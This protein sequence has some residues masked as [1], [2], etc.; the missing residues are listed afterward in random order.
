VRLYGRA[1]FRMVYEYVS[2]DG[3]PIAGGT[4]ATVGIDPPHR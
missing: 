3:Q 1:T 4:K 2:I